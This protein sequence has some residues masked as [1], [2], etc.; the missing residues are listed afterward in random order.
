[1][2]TPAN[3]ERMGLS[4]HTPGFL[5]L[6]TMFNI[7]SQEKPCILKHKCVNGLLFINDHKCCLLFIRDHALKYKI[8]NL[9]EEQVGDHN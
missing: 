9:L 7:P 5:L 2:L 4:V 8:I 3:P 1:M 6:L